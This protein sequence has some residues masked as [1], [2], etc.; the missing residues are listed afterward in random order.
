MTGTNKEKANIDYSSG[1]LSEKLGEKLAAAQ[2]AQALFRQQ[3]FESIF[4]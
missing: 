4:R 1:G 3:S 2:D